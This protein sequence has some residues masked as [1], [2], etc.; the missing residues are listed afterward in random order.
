MF[1]DPR[2]T[3]RRTPEEC[4]VLTAQDHTTPDGVSRAVASVLQTWNS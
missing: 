3:P 1:I 2:A 4:Y